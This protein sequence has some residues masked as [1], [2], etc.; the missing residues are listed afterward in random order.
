MMMINMILMM[1]NMVLML[2]CINNDDSDDM[3]YL[4]IDELMP[5]PRMKRELTFLRE[6]AT[7]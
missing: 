1:I 2:I 5:L 6:R 4:A 3:Y 7:Y